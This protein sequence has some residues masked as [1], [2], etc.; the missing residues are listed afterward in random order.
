MEEQAND[1]RLIKEMMMG[2]T[3]A[4][5]PAPKV[6]R[7]DPVIE[8][9]TRTSAGEVTSVDVQ[10]ESAVAWKRARKMLKIGGKMVNNAGAKVVTVNGRL[11]EEGDIVSV[12]MDGHTYRWRIK[13][14]TKQRVQFD[15][16]P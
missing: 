9:P 3:Q 13:S 8:P 16:V 7:K 10:E 15:Q 14:I 12:D 4:V 11:L 5:S 2:P 1:I 6:A